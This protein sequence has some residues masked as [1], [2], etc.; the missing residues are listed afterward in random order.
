MAPKVFAIIVTYKR[1]AIL[2]RCLQ[3]LARQ[4][5][6]NLHAYIIVNSN[7]KETESV[8][9]SFS[10]SASFGVQYKKLNNE[11]PAGGFHEGLKQFLNNE[12]CDFAWL[13]DDDVVADDNCL[14]QLLTES[15]NGKYVYPKV[16]TDAGKE[17]VSFGW[18]GVLVHKELVSKVGLPLKDLFYWAE[19]TEYLLHRIIYKHNVQPIRSKEAQVHHLHQRG[20][21][22]PSW[23]Y[24]YVPRNTVYYRTYISGYNWFRIRR[25]LYLF[26]SLIYTILFKEENK[27]RKLGLLVRGFIHGFGKKIGKTID[28]EIW[29]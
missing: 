7:D 12:T 3:S 25:T 21:K 19:D 9:N 4:N 17:I 5:Y 11:G 14:Q 16:I 26:P 2:L 27:F 24:Y 15:G 18:W 20:V 29:K 10:A 28:P 23:Y 6:R 22:R 1:P 8:I 13:M